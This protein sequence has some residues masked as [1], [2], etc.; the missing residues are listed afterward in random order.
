MDYLVTEHHAFATT[1][2]YTEDH[3]LEVVNHVDLKS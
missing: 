1:G 2:K 3:R